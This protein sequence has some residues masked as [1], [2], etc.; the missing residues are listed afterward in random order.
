M[1]RVHG[2]H[3]VALSY[4]GYL[5]DSKEPATG[6]GLWSQYPF[7]SLGESLELSPMPILIQNREVMLVLASLTFWE[8]GRRKCM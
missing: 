8:N 6:C 4:I 7:C 3:G 2:N 5:S 1:L